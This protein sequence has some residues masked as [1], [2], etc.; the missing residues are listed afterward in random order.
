MFLVAIQDI[1]FGG[2]L[3]DTIFGN[4]GQDIIFG[5][6]AEYDANIEF[7]PFQNYRSIIIWPNATGDDALNGGPD[8]DF[9]FGQEG[10][11]T[12][13]GG[14]GNDDITGGHDVRYGTDTDDF[15]NGE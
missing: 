8:D 13:N 7:L 1:A 4:S 2:S 15:L 5:D 6:F 9:I 12:V 11:D 10:K 14:S 3:S